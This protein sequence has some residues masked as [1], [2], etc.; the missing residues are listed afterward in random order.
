[1]SRKLLRRRRKSKMIERKIIALKKDELA[2]KEF[3]KKSLGKGRLSGIKIERTPLGERVIVTTAR[4]GGIIGKKGENITA[5]TES[6]KVKFKLQNPKVEIAEIAKPEFDAQT[7]ADQIAMSL[8]RFGSNSFKIIAYRALEKIKNAGALGC[9]I[10]LSGKLPSEKARSWRFSYGY[11]KKTGEP[12]N[13][14]NN[15]QAIA[16][17]K[18]G[19][20]G[21]KVSILPPDAYMPDRIIISKKVVVAEEKTPAGAN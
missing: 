4:P 6:L 18:P 13:L 19:I 7:V 2:I 5:L 16:S 1:M 15:A 12:A 14:V 11:L 21:I 3:V 20:T 9:E 17:T 10:V 8:E